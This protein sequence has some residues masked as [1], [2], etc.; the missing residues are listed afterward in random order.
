MNQTHTHVVGLI[1]EEQSD[2]TLADL[3]QS[4][5]VE[6]H[7]VIEMVQEGVLTPEGRS[8]DQWRFTGI[9]VQRTRVAVRLQRDLGV[10]HEGAALALQLLDEI[11]ALKAQ[12]RVAGAAQG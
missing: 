9:H 5:R 2:L 10:N 3:C 1:H 6:T 11:E 4:C 8:P 7:L 12:L